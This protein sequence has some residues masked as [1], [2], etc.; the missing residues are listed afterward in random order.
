MPSW[1]GAGF[2]GISAALRLRALGYSV[3]LIDRCPRGS[4]VAHRSSRR[5]GF[6]HDAG[7]TVLTAPGLFEELFL[8]CS[9]KDIGDYVT[10][11]QPDPVVSFLVS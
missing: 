11:V 4:V 1:A 2:G 6:R 9:A 10:L 5:D 3:H 8:A 7:P